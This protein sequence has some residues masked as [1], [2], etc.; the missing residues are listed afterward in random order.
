METLWTD[1][2]D[3]TQK[4]Y[5]DR[6]GGR[7][8]NLLGWRCSCGVL[9][10]CEMNT[11]PCGGDFDNPSY[12]Q[13]SGAIFLSGFQR[14]KPYVVSGSEENGRRSDCLPR[15]PTFPCNAHA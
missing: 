12:S 1:Q 13:F 4:S 11:S 5:R 2:N 8:R 10:L 3:L 15:V 9:V 14:Q 7:F 6:A